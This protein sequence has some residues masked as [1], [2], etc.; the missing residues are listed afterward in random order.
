MIVGSPISTQPH[1]DRTVRSIENDPLPK[2]RNVESANDDDSDTS[3]ALIRYQ[4]QQ[5][6][7][8]YKFGY[9]V[10]D[11]QYRVEEGSPLEGILGSYGYVDTNGKQVKVFYKADHHGFQILTPQ[12]YQV[13]LE[14]K[15]MYETTDDKKYDK[16]LGEQSE[17]DHLNSKHEP[18]LD[19]F[20]TDIDYDL[21]KIKVPKVN[22]SRQNF[23]P[24]SPVQGHVNHDLSSDS[25]FYNTFNNF[26]IPDREV[27]PYNDHS[28]PWIS[29]NLRFQDSSVISPA[30]LSYRQAFKPYWSFRKPGL[31][32][33]H[34][35][36]HRSF[37][38][39]RF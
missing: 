24:P 28:S 6:S 23:Q 21:N 12:M 4:A 37:I 36:V 11:G 10:A 39:F 1:Y 34:P 14:A 30:P 2:S 5:D 27:I 26:K 8:Y 38:S 35:I 22:F 29:Q 18:P 31:S 13:L 25:P 16:I 3:D 9:A 17:N 32:F 20:L 15:H 33:P 19:E 7:G